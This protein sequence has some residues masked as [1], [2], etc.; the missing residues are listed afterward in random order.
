MNCL[1]MVRFGSIA[2]QLCRNRPPLYRPH[3]S[4]R[5]LLSQARRMQSPCSAEAHYCWVFSWSPW[6]CIA[7]CSAQDVVRPSRGSHNTTAI[8]STRPSA[9]RFRALISVTY[10]R[11]PSGIGKVV[12]PVDR[13]WDVA[14]CSTFVTL[15]VMHDA[16]CPHVASTY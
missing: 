14:S 8:G 11:V 1:K 16:L 5:S 13:A 12:P 3:R 2:I 10:E 7:S 4:S 9:C 15:P 6:Q